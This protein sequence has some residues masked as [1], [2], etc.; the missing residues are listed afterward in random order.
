MNEQ[1]L[2]TPDTMRIL[3]PY[4]YANAEDALDSLVL[5]LSP[6]FWAAARKE[7]T[8]S[9]TDSVGTIT[10]WSGGANNA[11][12]GTAGERGTYR[13]GI[14][15]GHEAFLLDGSNDN[16]VVATNPISNINSATVF[17]V[18]KYNNTSTS[19]FGI[20]CSAGA[21]RF[22][23][24]YRVAGNWYFG[25]AGSA[26]AIDIGAPD[27]NNNIWTFDASAGAWINGV[28]KGTAA[29]VSA[30]DVPATAL[31]GF[32]STYSFGGY[33]AEIIIYDS[34]LSQANRYAIEDALSLVY[35]IT[36]TH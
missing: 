14:I 4:R 20:A 9:D 5:S 11:T 35:G 10:D 26:T 25:Y 2:E 3:N 23:C 13:T 21:A 30:A 18:G 32:S 1:I 24:M 29:Q 6:T 16:Y 17:I 22:Y 31:I 12:Q 15:N 8:Y 7:T 34:V 33:M 36:V 27:T 19:D 28:S